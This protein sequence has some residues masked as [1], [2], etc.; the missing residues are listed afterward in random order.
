MGELAD[1]DRRGIAVAGDAEIDQV[2]VGERRAGQHRRHPAVHLLK[3]VRVAEKYV[4]VFDEQPMPDSLAARCGATLSSKNA[5]M[6][7]DEIESW[8]QP[9]QSVEITFVVAMGIAERILRQRRMMDSWF[10]QISHGFRDQRSGIRN[11]KMRKAAMQHVRPYYGATLRKG[12]TLNRR[13][14]SE[15]SRVMKRAVIG[16]PS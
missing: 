5:W 15:I 14:F 7:D 8:P 6:I 13:A 4:G 10:G 11:Q 3:L 12:V 9:A 16:V 1:A 2:A